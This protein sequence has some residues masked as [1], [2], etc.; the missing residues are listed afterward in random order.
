[1]AL[2]INVGFLASPG[3]T[4]NQSIAATLPIAIMV[5]AVPRSGTGSNGDADA[6]QSFGFGTYRG[7]VVQQA[8]CTYFSQHGQGNAVVARGT[9][10]DALLKLYS[11]GTTPTVDLEIDLVSMD[12]DEVIIN[13]VNLHTTASVWIYYMVIG[14]SEVTDA[15][16]FDGSASA[17]VA[18]QDFTL[19]GGTFGQPD[20]LLFGAAGAASLSDTATH[21]ALTF[22]VAKSA[23][24]RFC[25]LYNDEDAANTMLGASWNKARALLFVNPS[26]QAVDGEADLSAEASWPSSGFQLTY[27]DQLSSAQVFIGLALKG[28]FSATVGSTDSPVSSSIVNVS[29]GATPRAVFL[30]HA[31]GPGTSETL[32]ATAAEVGSLSIGIT[33]SFEEYATAAGNDDGVGTSDCFFAGSSRPATQFATTAAGGA[34]TLWTAAQAVNFLSTSI[35]IDWDIPTRVA[36]F[37]M[38]ILGDA[39]AA[40]SLPRRQRR[41]QRYLTAR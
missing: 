23:T 8:Y 33:D 9:G 39:A 1:M 31:A 19:G 3:A 26:T 12:A 2:T 6:S 41:A 36:R 20:L 37:G 35:D 14:G 13:F 28:T 34:P 29:H 18:T 27:A 24:E 15:V 40:T 30:F 25:S 16:A 7:S 5:M 21:S 17:S 22:G 11:D 4:G 10:N 38:A 32:S